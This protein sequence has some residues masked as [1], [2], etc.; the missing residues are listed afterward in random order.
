MNVTNSMDHHHFEYKFS[1][2]TLTK[3]FFENVDSEA[4]IYSLVYIP[5]LDA[6]CTPSIEHALNSV[7]SLEWLPLWDGDYD[8][9]LHAT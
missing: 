5:D 7:A 6:S 2:T 3:A 4:M 1:Q 9:Q 8:I